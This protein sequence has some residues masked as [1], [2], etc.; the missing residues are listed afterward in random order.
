MLT[1]AKK[2]PFTGRVLTLGVQQ[3]T[4]REK[5]LIDLAKRVQYP[6]TAVNDDAVEKLDRHHHLTDVFL[7]K[8]LGFDEVQRTDFSD[9]QGAELVFDMNQADTPRKHVGRYDMVID[10]GTVEH[11]FHIPNSMAHIFRFLKV[12]GRIIHISPSSNNIDHGFYMFSPTLFWDFYEA[13]KFEFSS[14][15]FIEYNRW[16]NTE[17]WIAGDYEP[18]CL[19]YISGGGL[20]RGQYGIT[21]TAT[22]TE[23]ST[24]DVVPQMNRYKK[25]WARSTERKKSKSAL[26]YRFKKRA[27]RIWK[28]Y[29]LWTFPLRVSDRF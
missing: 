11:V 29:R 10:G 22:K 15:K 21:L 12:G 27:G 26:H 5:E 4:I 1:E 6:L 3:T 20:P 13:N 24:S 28:K 19:H 9:F 7:F 18:G 2:Q 8:S 14:F 17:K 16:G 25:T 23:H